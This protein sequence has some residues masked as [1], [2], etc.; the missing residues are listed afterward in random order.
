M[1]EIIIEGILLYGLSLGLT[2][3]DGNEKN[4]KVTLDLLVLR[5]CFSFLR[6]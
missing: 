5:F 6:D 2:Y 1:S 3:E 4:F